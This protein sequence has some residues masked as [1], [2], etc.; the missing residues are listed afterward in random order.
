MMIMLLVMMMI[1]MMGIRT[2]TIFSPGLTNTILMGKRT[3]FLPA[4]LPFFAP[5]SRMLCQSI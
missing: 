1:E 4:T 2:E 3:P 5:E